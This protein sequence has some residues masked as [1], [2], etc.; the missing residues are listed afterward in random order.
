MK[1][2]VERLKTEARNLSVKCTCNKK[3]CILCKP[4]MLIAEAVH[5]IEELRSL[6]NATKE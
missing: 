5:E 4:K 2:L 1:D 3:D 6:M